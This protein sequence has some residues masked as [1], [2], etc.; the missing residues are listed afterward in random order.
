ML[1]PPEVLSYEI[2]AI[3]MGIYTFTTKLCGLLAAM[4]IPFGLQALGY[5][6]YFVNACFDV[7]MVGKSRSHTHL[8]LH[9]I[10]PIWADNDVNSFRSVRLGR[11]PWPDPRRGRQIVR[12]EQTRTHRGADQGRDRRGC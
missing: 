2:R 9:L 12:R 10:L 4:A 11:D 8:L 3:G 5:Q 7:L 1:Y 6:F